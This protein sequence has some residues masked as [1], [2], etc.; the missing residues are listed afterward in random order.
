MVQISVEQA[1]LLVQV[2]WNLGLLLLHGSL[3]LGFHQ[4][5]YMGGTEQM[6]GVV[7]AEAGAS[8]CKGV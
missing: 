2:P 3:G 7:E 5:S 6:W 8:A 4:R 1:R